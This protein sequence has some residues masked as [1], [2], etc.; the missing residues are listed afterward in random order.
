MRIKD[1]DFTE[2]YSE[3]D[4]KKIISKCVSDVKNSISNTENLVLVGV[5][6]GGVPLLNEIAF[7]MPEN[8]TLDYVKAVSYG[9]NTFSSG[10]IIL[11]LDTQVEINGRDVVLVD[12]IIDSGR[13]MQFLKDHMRKKGARS[14]KVCSLFYKKNE[15]S[16]EPDFYGEMIN[17]KFIIGFGLDYAQKGRN[18]KNILKLND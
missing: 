8:I 7:S 4:L 14:V 1:R 5:L 9:N 15:M 16:I 17:E 10:E 3:Q 18:L 13:T 6:N 2:L 11:L 12:D